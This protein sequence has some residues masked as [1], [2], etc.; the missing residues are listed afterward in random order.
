[1]A[2]ENSQTVHCSNYSS[3]TG[4]NKL[5]V[6]QQLLHEIQLGHYQLCSTPPPIVSSIGAIA[7]K[8]GG[9]R[10]IHDCSRPAGLSVNSYAKKQCFK[11]KTVD[12]AVKL[13]P[14]N[15]WM[16][17]IDLSSAYRSVPIHPSCYP[18]MGLHW[19]FEGAA[20]PSYFYDTRLCFGGTECPEKFQRLSN[21][22]TR[23]MSRRGHTVLAYLDDFLVVSS[24]ELQCK[25]AYNE[26]ICLLQSLGFTINWDKVIPPA[27]SVTFLGIQIDSVSQTLSLPQDKLTA[28]KSLLTTWQGVKKTS[29][30]KLQQLIGT[31]CWAARMVAGGRVFLRRLISAM[32]VLKSKHHHTRLSVEARADI[33]WWFRFIEFFNGTVCFV[34]PEPTACFTSDA[35]MSGG[36]G[37]LH[38]DWFYVNW[39]VDM[40]AYA[41]A[42]INIKELLALTMGVR[43]WAPWYRDKHI[44]VYTDSSCVMYMVNKGTSTNRVA[45]QLIR[46]L[47]WI[48]VKF[49][50]HLSARHIRG[51]DNFASDFVSRLDEHPSWPSDLINLNLQ[52]DDLIHHLTPRCLVYLQG[53]TATSGRS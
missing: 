16:A 5:L 39:E 21:A 13:L 8:S 7:K 27:Q 2:M 24:D 15:G 52:C 43:R 3:A 47:F 53:V 12:D 38:P 32:C 31:L 36:G 40:P 29:K 22:V 26:L 10:I 51:V 46:E 42:H 45:M 19:T 1:M 14:A 20:S 23:M 11:Y 18:Y 33:L 37:V 44:V 6:E 17:K 35:C 34:T 28:L 9:I 30:H 49:N 50:C 48:T 41:S 25:L 4:E